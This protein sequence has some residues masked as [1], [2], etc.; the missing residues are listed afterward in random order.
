MHYIYICVYI[1]YIYVYTSMCIHTL[2]LCVYIYYI[3]IYM[4]IHILYISKS[5]HVYTYI[6]YLLLHKYQ[7]RSASPS[8]KPLVW[9]LC[10]CY[11]NNNGNNI[12]NRWII[13][14][15]KKCKSQNRVTQKHSARDIHAQ[16]KFS[17]DSYDILN[18]YKC[19][20]FSKNHILHT[21][22]H[23]PKKKRPAH[24]PHIPF[25]FFL[26]FCTHPSSARMYNLSPRYPR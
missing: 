9:K 10:V 21:P 17:A 18:I 16:I 19:L 23:T 3:Y 12:Q 20:I 4:C 13:R 1:Y 25:V 6:I 15:F 24:T 11:L 26:L 5:L 14:D 22:P 8:R 2:Y 7:H